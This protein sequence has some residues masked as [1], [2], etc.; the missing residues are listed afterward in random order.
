LP[1]STFTGLP[2]TFPPTLEM[3]TPIPTTDPI[4]PAVR[5]VQ[6]Y[7]EYINNAGVKDDLKRA[8]ELMSNKLQCNPSD[9][10]SAD[11]YINYWWKLQVQYKLFD[12]GSNNVTAKLIY[13]T[14]GGA[15]N[16]SRAPDYVTYE[17]LEDNGS[18]KVYNARVDSGV[19]A[20]CQLTVSSP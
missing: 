18:L 15:P 5:T 13:Y 17:V 11:H 3:T 8:W 7:F 1:T 14:R 4:S 16:P 6:H 12:C 20:N 19:N 9:Q 2:A 10:C